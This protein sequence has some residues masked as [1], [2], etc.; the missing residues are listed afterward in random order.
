MCK[1]PKRLSKKLIYSGDDN[2]SAVEFKIKD[3]VVNVKFLSIFPNSVNQFYIEVGSK[4]RPM[5]V[6]SIV[7]PDIV[8]GVDRNNYIQFQTLANVDVR[9]RNG[10]SHKRIIYVLSQI[11][12]DLFE[13]FVEDIAFN[14]DEN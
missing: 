7:F 8:D 1:A 2:S 10:R 4:E 9:M 13:R 12:V 11:S 14:A 6:S 3:L 5:L